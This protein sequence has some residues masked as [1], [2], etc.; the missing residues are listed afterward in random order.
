[1]GLLPEVCVVCVWR[2]EVVKG[3]RGWDTGKSYRVVG[4]ACASACVLFVSVCLYQLLMLRACVE[5]SEFKAT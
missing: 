4:P 5:R 2:R 3:A 1:M